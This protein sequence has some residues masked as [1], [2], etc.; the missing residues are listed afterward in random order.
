MSPVGFAADDG[1]EAANGG[2]GGAAAVRAD[3]YEQPAKVGADYEY[4]SAGK[5]ETVLG[6]AYD[7]PDGYVDGGE[8]AYDD[9]GGDG[10]G[11]DIEF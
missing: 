8:A 3:T 11:D 10:G 5:S 9:M 6:D 7:M 4:A 1:G 2:G